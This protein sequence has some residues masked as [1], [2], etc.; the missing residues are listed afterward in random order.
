MSRCRILRGQ[1]HKILV[2]T[3]ADVDALQNLMGS[4]ALGLS[5]AEGLVS[6]GR[7]RDVRR[8]L[9]ADVGMLRLGLV[10]LRWRIWPEQTGTV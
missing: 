7:P 5:A 1:L 10:D 3:R 8:R 2:M 4:A 9:G 6:Q